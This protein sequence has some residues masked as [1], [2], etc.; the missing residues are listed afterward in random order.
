[1][2]QPPFSHF[3]CALPSI[4]GG[5]QTSANKHLLKAAGPQHE[6]CR[7]FKAVQS[8]YVGQDEKS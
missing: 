6:F 7:K 1:M 8:T 3:V 5:G 4:R 2:G